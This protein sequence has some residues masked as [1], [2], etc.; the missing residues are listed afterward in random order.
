MTTDATD[1]TDVLLLLATLAGDRAGVGVAPNTSLFRYVAIPRGDKD[2][3][4]FWKLVEE[5]VLENKIPLTTPVSFNDPFDSSPITVND[6]SL[7]EVA[8]V[9]KDVP[10]NADVADESGRVLNEA[11]KRQHILEVISKTIVHMNGPRSASFCRRISSQLLW[12]HYAGSYSGFAYHFAVSGSSNSALQFVHPVDYKHQRPIILAS[13]ILDLLD[14]NVSPQAG[15]R[16][17]NIFDRKAY[18]TKSSEWSY[19]EEERL[20][21]RR[22]GDAMFEPC[23]LPSIVI[24]PRFTDENLTKLRALVALRSRPLRLYRARLAESDYAI[25]VDWVNPL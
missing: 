9:V 6:V 20:L 14:S 24:G 22:K 21:F 7:D 8:R 25:E 2:A 4:R 17:Q 3:G 23:E 15:L 11:E 13:E 5:T 12:A 19:E 10:V 18:L 16:L 1:P